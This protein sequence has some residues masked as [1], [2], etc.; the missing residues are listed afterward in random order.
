MTRTD[1]VSAAFLTDV[2]MSSYVA[3][4]LDR[5]RWVVR[6]YGREAAYAVKRPFGSDL[7]IP[8]DRIFVGT[9]DEVDSKTDRNFLDE[10]G[11][12]SLLG[13][14]TA[15]EL[16]KMSAARDAHPVYQKLL[17][18]GA[19]TAIE[20]AADSAKGVSYSVFHF[21]YHPHPHERHPSL[22]DI[23]GTAKPR[24]IKEE[25]IAARPLHA[26]AV[27]KGDNILLTLYQQR[28][29]I[30]EKKFA[31]QLEVYDVY[32]QSDDMEK[33]KFAKELGETFKR[34]GA[35]DHEVGTTTDDQISLPRLF[36]VCGLPFRAAELE[37]RDGFNRTDVAD[38]LAAFEFTAY[39]PNASEQRD[40][41]RFA[42]YVEGLLGE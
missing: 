6:T 2:L 15:E 3:E 16:M 25:E 9:H 32:Q 22:D 20:R 33:K 39:K 34:L 30:E 13:F 12:Q 26:V 21:H 37:Y 35:Y 41:L 27:E 4:A 31:R 8:Q 42:E 14:R 17:V 10:Q 36:M 1:R 40:A 5:G 7:L 38:V 28:D 18:P 19:S 11:V 29:D 23:W 24:V